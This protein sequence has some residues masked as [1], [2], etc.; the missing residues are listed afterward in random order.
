MY[1]FILYPAR[2][3]ILFIY[4]FTLFNLW[5]TKSTFLIEYDANIIRF[6]QAGA[7]N[8]K[9]AEAERD[10]QNSKFYKRKL[11]YKRLKMRALFQNNQT[12]VGNTRFYGDFC[13]LFIINQLHKNTLFLQPYGHIK[14]LLLASHCGLFTLSKQCF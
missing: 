9:R 1:R 8:A 13:I 2:Y 3:F 5:I 10:N 4:Y 7:D 6:G 12:W 14:A 11:F